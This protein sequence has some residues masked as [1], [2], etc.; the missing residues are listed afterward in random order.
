MCVCVC[1]CVY[2]SVHVY[3]CEYMSVI[4]RVIQEMVTI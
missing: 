2:V 3:V 1:A 4:V